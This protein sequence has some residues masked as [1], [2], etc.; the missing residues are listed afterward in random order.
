[1]EW[2]WGKPDQSLSLGEMTISDIQRVEA[3]AK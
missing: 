3:A 1:M 2:E